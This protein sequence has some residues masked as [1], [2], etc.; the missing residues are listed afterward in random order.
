[1]QTFGGAAGVGR[2][3][4]EDRRP[5]FGSGLPLSVEAAASR[6]EAAPPVL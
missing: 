5:E 3:F 1:M 2:D 6:G 4:A